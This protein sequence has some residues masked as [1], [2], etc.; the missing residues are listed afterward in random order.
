MSSGLSLSNIKSSLLLLPPTLHLRLDLLEVGLELL[1]VR[2]LRG[3]SDAE[4]LL[5]VGLGNLSS[6]QVSYI[7]VS[8]L[9]HNNQVRSDQ[10]SK[11]SLLSSTFKR[12]ARIRPVDHQESKLIRSYHLILILQRVVESYGV[13]EGS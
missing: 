9:S 2:L 3:P 10:N 4:A 11:N 5:L 1:H 13:T 8:L 7:C 6:G 12:L